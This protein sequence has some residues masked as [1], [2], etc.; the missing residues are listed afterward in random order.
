MQ[1]QKSGKKK[2][3]GRQRGG[4][5][6]DL[7][8]RGSGT[9]QSRGGVAVGVA[10]GGLEANLGGHGERSEYTGCKWASLQ[11]KHRLESAVDGTWHR[12]LLLPLQCAHPIRPDAFVRG[13][14]VPQQFAAASGQPCPSASLIRLCTK[15]PARGFCQPSRP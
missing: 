9:W 13:S 11:P 5:R 6:T 1:S 2:N 10:C 4:P 7:A 3:V 8:G 15:P 12:Y 14:A